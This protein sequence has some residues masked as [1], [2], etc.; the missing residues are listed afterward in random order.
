MFSVILTFLGLTAV[1]FVIGRFM[2]IDPVIS[3]VGDKASTEVYDRVYKEL[4]L[5][6]P[7]V[8]QYLTYLARIPAWNSPAAT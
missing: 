1:T 4:G 2:P 7:V 5:D 3:I 6:Q 8:V